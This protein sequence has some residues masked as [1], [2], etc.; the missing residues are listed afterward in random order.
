MELLFQKKEEEIMKDWNCRESFEPVVSIKCLAYN[1]EKSI[2]KCIDGFLMQETTFPFEIIIHD[3]ASTDTTADIIRKYESKY[4]NIIK[5]IYQTENQY[6]KHNGVIRKMVNSKLNGKYIAFCEGDDCWT[7]SYK[8]Q[9]QVDYL[10]KHLE[11]SMTYHAV[12]YVNDG[13]VLR[14]DRYFNCETDVKPDL[15]IEKGGMFCST[16]SLCVRKDVYLEYPNFRLM[17]D[18]GDYPLQILASLRGVI[19]YFPKIMGEYQH[20]SSGSWS[21]RMK[22]NSDRLCKHF[23]K[24][25][26]W[27]K[28]LDCFTDYKYTE[29]IYF[30]LINYSVFGLYLSKNIDYS[31]VKEYMSKL[32]LGSNKLKCYKNLLK[33]RIKK[34][35]KK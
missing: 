20:Q 22:K 11:C 5:P 10:E 25:I 7:E 15:I 1:H 32:K 29:S 31:E 30:H 14:N 24:E 13:I 21:E 27:M 19:H 18:V 28:E 4:P 8:L 34:V 35:L 2:S 6:S 17:S 12:N 3:D 26:E 9:M 23:I 16:L 33:L